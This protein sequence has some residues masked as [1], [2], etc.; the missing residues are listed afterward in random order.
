MQWETRLWHIHT[1]ALAL[2]F[3]GKWAKKDIVVLT[4]VQNSNITMYFMLF[5]RSSSP[6]RKTLL[7]PPVVTNP[8]PHLPGYTTGAFPQ[9]LPR[10]TTSKHRTYQTAEKILNLHGCW[11]CKASVKLH[12]RPGP[13][14]QN[15]TKQNPTSATD[16]LRC[17]TQACNEN[18]LQVLPINIL[19]PWYRLVKH[20]AETL[21]AKRCWGKKSLLCSWKR[22]FLT[23]F[24]PF[25][26]AY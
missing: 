16:R 24:N 19:T 23:L 13:L 21:L 1:L 4:L 17:Q 14:W 3:L 6:R 5:N 26:K 10:A 25:R 20:P 15:Q 8:A 22:Q 7:L 11:H 2:F 12:N 9:L 18:S